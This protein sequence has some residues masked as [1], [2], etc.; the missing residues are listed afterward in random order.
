MGSLGENCG[1]TPSP[2][3][4]QFSPS[5]PIEPI[6]LRVRVFEPQQFTDST[7]SGITSDLIPVDPVPEVIQSDLL[8]DPANP[9]IT[10]TDN[11]PSSNS[12]GNIS[13]DVTDQPVT[14]LP[15]PS[16]PYSPPISIPNPFAINIASFVSQIIGQSEPT[17]PPV[18]I[19]PDTTSTGNTQP[20]ISPAN[21]PPTDSSQPNNAP[22]DTSPTNNPPT[23]SSLIDTPAT[24]LPTGTGNDLTQEPPC[25]SS[26]PLLDSNTGDDDAGSTP[27]PSIPSPSTEPPN[28]SSPIPVSDPPAATLKDGSSGRQIFDIRPG[29]GR[30]VI[31]NFGGVG[32]G[33]TPSQKIIDQVDTLRFIGS[34]FSPETM[35]LT[36]NGNDLIIRFENLDLE[37]VLQKFQLE[38]LDNFR[39]PDASVDLANILFSGSHSSEANF[40][41]FDVFDVTS[42]SNQIF[43]PNTTTYLNDLD[44]H[45]TGFDNSDDVINGQ[46]GNDSL[47]GLGGNDILRGGAGDDLLA[48]GAGTNRLVGD[49]GSDT[50]V[51][52]TA[53]ISI[54]DDFD[55][56]VDHIGLP[57]GIRLEQL[58]V[59]QGSGSSATDSWIRLNGVDLMRLRGVSADLLTA[60]C[61]IQQVD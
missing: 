19:S 11:T 45:V 41:A 42:E 43:N 3:A 53:G 12:S 44:N 24:E 57:D 40:D 36:Q 32:Q 2:D 9:I 20:E 49:S 18:V 39:R 54:V 10:P 48:G 58:Q 38:N 50:F 27:S 25:N 14:D 30:V 31:T 28:I 5:E 35:L 37:V 46:G 1:A 7:D 60:D 4:P 13:D 15:K 17:V 22:T 29:D 61:F 47:L 56:T 55:P 52:S 23:S 26:D 16:Q 6:N 51:L 8:T 21:N 34:E 59:V 33:T